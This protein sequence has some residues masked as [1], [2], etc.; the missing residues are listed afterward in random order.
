M[1]GQ[2]ERKRMEIIIGSTDFKSKTEEGYWHLM[3]FNFVYNTECLDNPF[4]MWQKLSGYRTE[5]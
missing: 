1:G 2:K 4:L 5:G 3:W